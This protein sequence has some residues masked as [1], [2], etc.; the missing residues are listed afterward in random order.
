MK[1]IAGTW[2]GEDAIITSD[3]RGDLLL[4]RR[5]SGGDPLALAPAQPFRHPDGRPFKVA[6]RSRPDFVSTGFAGAPRPSLV[7]MDLDGDAALAIPESEGSLVISEV[8]KLSLADGGNIRLCGKNGLWGRGHLEL[9]DWDG[10]GKEDI[11]F[12]TNQSCQRFFCKRKI[13]TNATPFLYRNVGTREKPLFAEPTPFRLAK[14]GNRLAFGCHNATPWATDLD[15][16]GRPDLLVSA[17]NGKVYAFRHDEIS[18]G[19]EVSKK[20]GN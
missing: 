1:V 2:G 16:D 12:G 7:I 10:D 3:I 19:P 15:G 13:R 4:H 17:E 11:I 18:P 5:A 6:W 9:V 8:R 14:N 20:K